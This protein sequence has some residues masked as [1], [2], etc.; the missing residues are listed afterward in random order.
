MKTIEVPLSLAKWAIEVLQ[1]TREDGGSDLDGGYL[2]DMAEGTGVIEPHQVTEPCDP[3]HC[4]CAEVSE[5]PMECYRY[6]KEVQN[7]MRA[8]AKAASD[9]ASQP[10]KESQ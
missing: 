7:A 6:T 8:I 4:A 1:A 9:A 5:F 3:T 10:D 2:F